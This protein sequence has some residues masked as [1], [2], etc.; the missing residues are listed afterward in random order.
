MSQKSGGGIENGMPSVWAFY[1]NGVISQQVNFASSNTV[2]FTIPAKASL[3]FGQGPKM[4]LLIDGVVVGSTVVTNTSIQNHV[5]RA[6][7][8]AGAHTVAIAFNND[9]YD[10]VTKQDRNLYV[11]KI[12][13]AN[14]V[15]NVPPKTLEAEQM[16]ASTGGTEPRGSSI[17]WAFYAGGDIKSNVNFEASGSYRLDVVGFASLAF[18]VGAA[19]DILVDGVKQGSGMV[20]STSMSTVSLDLNIASAGSHEV[21]LVFT[22]DAYDNATRSDRNLYLDKLIFTK[23]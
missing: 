21:K 9:D 20:S 15:I 16:S 14:V 10:F 19:F 17:V 6:Q 13:A 4:E 5:I 8:S 2:D 12:T 11:D 7:V 22:N 3:A 23:K 18:N 1:A